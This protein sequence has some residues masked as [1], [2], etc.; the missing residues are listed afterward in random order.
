M[1]AGPAFAPGRGPLRLA[2]LGALPQHEVERVFLG[3]VHLHALARA[4]L[5][6]ALARQ[7][8]VA[9]EAP[10]REVHVAGRGSVG[11]LAFLEPPDQLEH[12]RHVARG[13]RLVVG[14]F[15]AE[16]RHV[17]VHGAD[18]ALGERR[19]ALAL[20]GGAA[21]DL[22]VDVGDVAHVGDA[23][24]AGAQPALHHVEHH[25]HARM[26]EMAVVVHGHA[27]HVHPHFAR[28]QGHEVLLG[29]RHRVIDT[30]HAVGGG[31]R[32][33]RLG[34]RRAR[35]RLECSSFRSALKTIAQWTFE[36]FRA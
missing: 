4:Q 1:P 17:L 11:E 22:V 35:L 34:C 18:V 31:G 3:A 9:R 15:H 26:P 24:A 29:A 28:V 14:L 32:P 6:E 23:Q 20:L 5:V 2:R 10:H 13:A 27:A 30:Q 36:P 7:L 12:L 16:R 25:H 19:H 21:D 8:A 33:A